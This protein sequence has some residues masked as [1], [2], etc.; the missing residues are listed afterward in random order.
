MFASDKKSTLSIFNFI[1]N[2]FW[3]CLGY[4]SPKVSKIRFILEVLQFLAVKS[5]V[6]DLS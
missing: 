5:R 1:V 2:A 6:C 4:S 3:S